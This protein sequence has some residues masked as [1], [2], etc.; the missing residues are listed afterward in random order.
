MVRGSSPRCLVEAFLNLDT[1]SSVLD[2]LLTIRPAILSPSTFVCPEWWSYGGVSFVSFLP[3]C[4]EGKPLSLCWGTTNC[5]YRL[6]NKVNMCVVVC[7][8]VQMCAGECGDWR[9]SGS[10][11]P[12]RQYLSLAWSSLIRLADQQASISTSPALGLQACAALLGFLDEFWG[13]DSGL[14]VS[15]LSTNLPT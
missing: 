4:E 8:Y 2:Y 12:L 13:A 15:T 6:K 9:N 14:H 7:A 3:P 1:G 5:T 11:P 10:P